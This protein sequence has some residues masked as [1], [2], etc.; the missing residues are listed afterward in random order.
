MKRGSLKRNK[1]LN[2][3]SDRQRGK[4]KEYSV[5][6]KEYMMLHPFCEVCGQ[7]ATDI[8]H[9]A[10]RGANLCNKDTFLAIC[11]IC[12]T[13]AHDNPAWAKENGYTS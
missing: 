9:K 3:I 2:K 5:V 11:R 7:P 6:R 8:H 12:H 10:K 13:K 1:P 4:L